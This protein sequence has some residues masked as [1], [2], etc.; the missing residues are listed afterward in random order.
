M[1]VRM[2]VH[3]FVP[4]YDNEVYAVIIKGGDIGG[5]GEAQAPPP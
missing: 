2:Y 3:R 4:I 1:C 5:A